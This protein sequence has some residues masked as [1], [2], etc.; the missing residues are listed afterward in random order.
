MSPCLNGPPSWR[1]SSTE[2]REA[3]RAGELRFALA[4]SSKIPPHHRL[5][6]HAPPGSGDQ[7][8]PPPVCGAQPGSQG[9]I[10]GVN[11]CRAITPRLAWPELPD[12]LQMAVHLDAE[13]HQIGD[14]VDPWQDG[15]GLHA[16]APRN[17]AAS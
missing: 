2:C 7:L 8:I 4:A 11:P 15:S 16:R 10:H 1:R 5:D 14:A 3:R 17:V 9:R 13:F 12:L 6:S